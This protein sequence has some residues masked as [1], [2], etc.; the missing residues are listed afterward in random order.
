MTTPITKEHDLRA[1]IT[2]FL[3]DP[4]QDERSKNSMTAQVFRIALAA[5]DAELVAVING[6]REPVLY[7]EHIGIAI[8]THLYAAPPAPVVPDEMEPNVEA[9]KRV[10]PTSNPDEYAACIGADMWNACRAAILNHSENERDM[11]ERVS[12]SYRLREGV[13]A[14]R[15]SGIEIDAVKV[16]AELE[17]GNSPAIPDAWIAVSE[18]MPEMHTPV[19]CFGSIPEVS[20]KEFGFEGWLTMGGFVAENNSSSPGGCEKAIVTHWMPLPAEPQREGK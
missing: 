8:G 9:I 19:W 5:M 12:Q 13:A 4:A 20:G 16:L 17:N 1:F 3:T 2:G 15:N 11:V 10:L 7:G 18:R 6:A 14:L